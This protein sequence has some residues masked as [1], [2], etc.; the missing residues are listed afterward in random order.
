MRK[1]F[2]ITLLSLA[3]LARADGG[4][5]VATNLQQPNPNALTLSELAIDIWIDDGV[6]RVLVRQVYASH[7]GQVLEGKYSFAL[8]G[9]AMISDFAVWDGVTRIPGVILERKRAEEIYQDLRMQSIDPGLLKTGEDEAEGRRS[10]VFSAEVVPIPGYG[11]KR[12]EIEYHQ[13]VPVE[14]LQSVLAIP[15]KAGAYQQQTAGH[16]W[17]TLELRSSHALKDFAVTSKAYGLQVR[18]RTPHLV[19]ATYEGRNVALTEDFAVRYAFDGANAGK[20]DVIA[21]R[22]SDKEPGFF[23]ASGL[24]APAAVN[25]APADPRTV[26]VLFDNSLSMQWEKLERSFQ[27][28][29]GVL[30]ALGPNDRFNLLMFNTE[31]ETFQPAPVP[32]AT[33]TVERAL[34]WVRQRRFRGRTELEHAL[35]AGS[36]ATR[37]RDGRTKQAVPPAGPQPPRAGIAR[38]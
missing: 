29:E 32:A 1:R 9:R 36:G 34:E 3:T 24:L 16:F 12:V 14:D 31:V 21:H 37:E 5:L 2:A 8:P 11:S 25:N 17:I 7:V 27:A 28:M 26:V 13:T 6:A 35:A 15:L 4:V 18:E 33:A 10:A 23:Q 22:D 38:P 30:R 19:K 20:L